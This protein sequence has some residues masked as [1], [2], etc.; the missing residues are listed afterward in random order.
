M[1]FVWENVSMIAPA[2]QNTPMNK[3]I[4]IITIQMMTWFGAHVYSKLK[5]PSR[6]AFDVN[7]TVINTKITGHDLKTN[8]KTTMANNKNKRISKTLELV[9]ITKASLLYI[10]MVSIERQVLPFGF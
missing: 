9:L 5:T 8:E 3:S 4:S 2:V 7:I 1:W 10:T 6:T